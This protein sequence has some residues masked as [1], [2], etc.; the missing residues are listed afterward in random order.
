MNDDNNTQFVDS[1]SLEGQSTQ[2]SSGPPSFRL[3]SNPSRSTTSNNNNPTFTPVTDNNS[4]DNGS[5]TV[6]NDSHNEND[7]NL[8]DSKPSDELEDIKRD[9]LSKLSPLVEKLDQS[10]EEK[11]RTLMLLIQSSDNRSLIKSAYEAACQ[12]EDEDKKAEALLGVVNEIEYFSQNNKKT[13]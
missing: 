12:I 8:D 13:D 1:S 10:P 2:A 9:A 5:D 11:Y 7:T 3:G 4:Q 6:K